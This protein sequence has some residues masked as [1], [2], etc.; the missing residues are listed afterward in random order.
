MENIISYVNSLGVALQNLFIWIFGDLDTPLI[1]LL[2]FIF[3]DYLTGVINGCKNKEFCLSIALKGIIKKCL[4]L[5]VLLVGVMLD[6]LLDNGTWM[7]KG[8]ISYF[9]IIKE[10]TS[11]LTNCASLGVPI[12]EK[13][14]EALKQL[15][16]KKKSNKLFL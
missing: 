7:F 11:I 2:V 5:V 9:Y 15:D 1:T 3:L 13:L 12:P 4:I 16:N 10:G 6:R 8:L 14:K